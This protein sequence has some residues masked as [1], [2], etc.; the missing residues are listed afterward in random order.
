[1]F[2][3]L[4]QINPPVGVPS[5]L[6]QLRPHAPGRHAA[7]ELLPG[8]HHG[9]D[10]RHAGQPEPD[11]EDVLSPGADPGATVA[12]KVVSHLI[13]MGLLLV[14]V[15]CFGNWRAPFFIPGVIFTMAV[16]TIFA[17]G[18]SLLFSMGNVFYRDIQHFS[19]IFFFIWMFLTPMAYPYYIVGGGMNSPTGSVAAPARYIHLLGHAVSLG[20][21]FK[22]NPMTDAVLVFQSFLYNGA[23]PGSTHV[24]YAF[25]STTAG[26]TATARHRSIPTCHGATSCTW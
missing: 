22:L 25:A 17:L 5:G 3:F 9:V 12:S 21:L 10:G 26:H 15:V 4:L 8:Q 7:V 24:S 23:L 11:P 6:A 16:V 13:E 18:L 19:N 1:M 20:T 14:A 2:S